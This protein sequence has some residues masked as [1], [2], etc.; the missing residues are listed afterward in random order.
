MPGSAVALQLFGGSTLDRP[1]QRGRLRPGAIH[2]MRFKA[3]N[4]DE[5]HR[6]LTGTSMY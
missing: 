5:F 2:G 6:L 1:L 4:D 3:V